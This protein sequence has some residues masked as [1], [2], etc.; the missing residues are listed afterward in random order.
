[1]V[2]VKDL[3]PHRAPFLFV[4]EI[5]SVSKEEIVAV[6]V[7]DEDSSWL[8]GSFPGTNIIPGTILIESMA[9][10]GGAGVKLLKIVPDA[11]FGLVSITDAQF[12]KAA[13]Y[14]REIRYVIKNIRIS[15]KMIKQSGVAYMDGEPLL[16]ATWMCVKLE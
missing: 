9:Q 14:D 11:L 10:C 1:M 13:E 15:E 8:K 6:K 4:D 3:L 7:F 12:L 16:E 2:E 5:I